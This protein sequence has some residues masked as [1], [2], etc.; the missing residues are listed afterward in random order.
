[1]CRWTTNINTT[2]V[3]LA[4]RTSSIT[5]NACS[6]SALHT[7]F[8]ILHFYPFSA[9]CSSMD[10]HYDTATWEARHWKPKFR[11]SSPGA[12][13]N[14]QATALLVL[15]A[16]VCSRPVKLREIKRHWKIK[17]VRLCSST[18]GGGEGGFSIKGWAAPKDTE[19]YTRAHLFKCQINTPALLN[20]LMNGFL[21][22]VSRHFLFA[23]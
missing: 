11:R 22:K 17:E 21:E 10:S 23:D 19:G 6:S 14:Q 16:D 7:L 9:D 2:H 20:W 12:C 5:N 3:T 1:M 4:R 15:S 8:V 13:R 18:E